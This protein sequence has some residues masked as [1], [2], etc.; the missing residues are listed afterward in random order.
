M[1]KKNYTPAG[2]IIASFAIMKNYS[3]TNLSELNGISYSHLINLMNGQRSLEEKHIVKIA[4]ALKLNH[5]QREELRS[6]AFI[7]NKRIEINNEKG[8]INNYILLA[9]YA[10]LKKRHSISKPEVKAIL[11]LI[12]YKNWSKSNDKS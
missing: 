4:D 8:D 11:D 12:G 7:S 3:I 6:N 1:N 9:I 10:I 2:K 5:D